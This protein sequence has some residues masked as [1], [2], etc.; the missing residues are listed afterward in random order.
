ACQQAPTSPRAAFLLGLCAQDRGDHATAVAAYERALALDPA[1]P[2]AWTNL[3]IVRQATGDLV[4]ARA[5]YGAALRGRAS[6]FGRISQALA[7][8]PKGELWLDLEG[9]RRDLAG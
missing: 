8:A 3:G 2:E 9:L 1:L 7:G 4:G 5:A 6:A